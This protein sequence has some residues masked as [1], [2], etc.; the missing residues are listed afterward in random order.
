M[1]HL[2]TAESTCYLAAGRTDAAVELQ[3]MLQDAAQLGGG[4]SLDQP[5][6]GQQAGEEGLKVQQQLIHH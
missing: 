2:Q 5:G 6:S 4:V 3:V 1:D